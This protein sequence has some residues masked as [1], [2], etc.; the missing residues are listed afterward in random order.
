MASSSPAAFGFDT[1][2][3]VHQT[4]QAYADALD[5]GDID[6]IL[7]CFDADAEW[8]YSPT[9]MRRGHREIR[10]FFEER[11]S[12]WARTSH[13][14]CEPVL[15]PGSRPGEVQSSVYFTSEHILQDG[16]RYRGCGRYVD[17]INLSGPRPLIT[18]RQVL[19]HILEGSNRVYNYLPRIPFIPSH[20]PA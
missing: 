8:H 20:S 17:N 19:A 1:W 15:A 3:A 16:S 2:M 10:A 13:A 11:M 14:V 4:V 18:R 6:G 12:V 5:H 9:A 7:A